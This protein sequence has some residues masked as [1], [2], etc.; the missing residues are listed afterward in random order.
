MVARSGSY[1]L[2]FEDA[3]QLRPHDGMPRTGPC[4]VFPGCIGAHVHVEQV[5]GLF[6][7]QTKA[8]ALALKAGLECWHGI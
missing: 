7:R 1:H 5:S 3:Q 2:V 4:S 8:G 6:L